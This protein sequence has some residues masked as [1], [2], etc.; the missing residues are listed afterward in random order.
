MCQ[1][2]TQI[3]QQ[4]G[5]SKQTIK[6]IRI[7][8]LKTVRIRKKSLRIHNTQKEHLTFIRIR[9][10]NLKTVRIRKKTLR[11]NNTQKEHLT[12]IQIHFKE[13][14]NKR[15]LL[16]HITLKLKRPTHLYSNTNCIKI[17]SSE[18]SEEVGCSNEDSLD[19]ERSGTRNLGL[20]EPRDH[21]GGRLIFLEG[22]QAASGA[23][24]EVEPENK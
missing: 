7:R 8:D 15:Q 2:N 4:T 16:I 3:K 20:V 1:A 10:R 24:L 17:T 12:F 14:K 19:K 9:I 5:F 11:I 6:R 21:R 23:D 13:R 22:G 18:F